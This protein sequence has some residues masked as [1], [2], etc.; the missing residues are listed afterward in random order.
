MCYSNISK[1]TPATAAAVVLG[2]LAVISMAATATTTDNL[3]RMQAHAVGNVGISFGENIDLSVEPTE[4]GLRRRLLAKQHTS[5]ATNDEEEN[6]GAIEFGVHRKPIGWANAKRVDD[7]KLDA[8][9]A[10]KHDAP[11]KSDGDGKKLDAEKDAA[12]K[13][14][15]DTKPAS[16]ET[17]PKK[18]SDTTPPTKDEKGKAQLAKPAQ[19]NS[20]KDVDRYKEKLK[21]TRE[22]LLKNNPK[23][24]KKVEAKQKKAAEDGEKKKQ[25]AKEK[26]K[27]TQKDKEKAKAGDDH[28]LGKS[29]SGAK[30]D[31]PMTGG[32]EK[33]AELDEQLRKKKAQESLNDVLRKKKDADDAKAKAKTRN[34]AD[35]EK[36][37]ARGKANDAKDSDHQRRSRPLRPGERVF[38][39]LPIVKRAYKKTPLEDTFS[40]ATLAFVEGLKHG[41][42]PNA[43]GHLDYRRKEALREWLAL[44]SA[45]LPPELALHALINDL[46]A[47]I[48]TVSKMKSNLLKTIKKH[49]IKERKWSAAC[50]KAGKR[51]EHG[52]FS[53]AFWKLLHIVSVGLAEQRGGMDVGKED[54]ITPMKAADTLRE[55]MA[56][57]FGCDVCTRNF[58]SQYDQCAYRRCDRLA[59][60]AG[61]LPD[62]EW[63]ELALYLWEFHNGV[64]VSVYHDKTDTTKT[65]GKDEI[66]VIYPNMEECFLCLGEDGIF[67][68]EQITRHLVE[69]YWA[70]PERDSKDDMLRTYERSLERPLVSTTVLYASFSM[71][72]LAAYVM[73]R[74]YIKRT[75][76]HKKF[77]AP[78][79]NGYSKTAKKWIRI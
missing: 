42:F 79:S 3:S 54:A 49:P 74:R 43:V 12:E 34:N 39:K 26:E 9:D 20:M 68:D 17:T 65:K 63:Y 70:G 47:N 13:K 76:F 60:S 28:D 30:T 22:E 19:P 46:M 71:M 21:K 40:D 24:K 15:E 25:K 10:K 36:K 75:G 29:T 27:E 1:M 7:R 5:S 16:T 44:L 61:D 53:C 78:N 62:E 45:S 23:L 58:I 8:D 64:S 31:S 48:D 33:L 6:A 66:S 77:D 38:S 52:G 2:A 35:D 69:T 14:T 51:S 59:E 72:L 50:S 57:F 55:Y 67:D 56:L 11:V 18:M 73:K 41:V 37:K 4:R 32:K